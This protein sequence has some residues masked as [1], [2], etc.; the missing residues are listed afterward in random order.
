MISLFGLIRRSSTLLTFSIVFLCSTL[1][2]HAN[3]A[4]SLTGVVRDQEGKFCPGL[5][6][7]LVDLIA[8][9]TI[10]LLITTD[11]VGQ[12]NARNVTAGSY[13]IMVKSSTYQGPFDRFVKILPGKT[14]VLS[15]VVHQ[16]LGLGYEGLSAASISS[17]LRGSGSHRMI[18]RGVSNENIPE[19]SP[20][21]FFEEAVFDVYTSAGFGSRS[22]N[23]SR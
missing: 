6:I 3:S 12:I 14:A 4:G 11:E 2:V 16:I 10:P 1:A 22:V 17:L 23:F 9:N 7:S 8:R 13:Q 15:L 20:K 5:L 18:F 19:K 21:P